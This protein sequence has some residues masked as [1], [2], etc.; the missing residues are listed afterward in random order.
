MIVSPGL[1]TDQRQPIGMLV[2]SWVSPCRAHLDAADYLLG[3]NVGHSLSGSLSSVT[4]FLIRF[5]MIVSPGLLMPGKASIQL[6]AIAS[7]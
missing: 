7:Q 6:A 2:A 5:A 3:V 4:D 1:F